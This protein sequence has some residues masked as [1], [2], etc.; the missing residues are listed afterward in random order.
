MKG[1]ESTI[2]TETKVTVSQSRLNYYT[3]F[4]CTSSVQNAIPQAPL[5][6]AEYCSVQYH[7]RDYFK[8]AVINIQLPSKIYLIIHASTKEKYFYN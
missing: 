8:C 3:V 7:E 2:T 6:L 4:C 1:T 5:S